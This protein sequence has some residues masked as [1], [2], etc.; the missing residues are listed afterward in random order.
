MS[1]WPTDGSDGSVATEARWR[2]MGR[3]WTPS[4]V[5]TGV[6]NELAPTLAY[7]NLTIKAG[8]AWVDGHYCELATAQTLTVTANGLAVVRFDPAANS[9]QLLWRDGVSTP[10]QDPNGVW[11]LPLYKTV[12]GVGTDLRVKYA[13]VAPQWKD[14]ATSWTSYVPGATVGNGTLISRYNLINKTCAILID[15][16]VGTTTSFG[17]GIWAFSLPF[18]AAANTGF[19]LLLCKGYTFSTNQNWGGWAQIPAG[20]TQLLPQLSQ[21]TNIAAMQNVQNCD[22]SLS[23]GTG[24]PAVAGTYTWLPGSGLT[25]NGTY[26]IA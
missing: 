22:N 21:G 2:K 20:S 3:L 8:A 25:I 15:L 16:R 10:A 12:G 1:V 4:S 14:Y 7:P 19:Q 17:G 5:A 6:A 18:A 26:E 9:A 13:P 24:V 11:E 23:P